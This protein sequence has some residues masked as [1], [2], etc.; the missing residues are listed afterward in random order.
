MIAIDVQFIENG[1][2]LSHCHELL[3][4]HAS[5]HKLTV[6]NLAVFRLICH[7]HQCLDLSFI[8][9]MTI[10]AFVSFEQLFFG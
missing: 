3:S 6:T 9:V 7:C 1:F 4:V 2:Q 10:V 8:E 5:H